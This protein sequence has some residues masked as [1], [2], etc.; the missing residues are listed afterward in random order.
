MTIK[1]TK[2][3]KIEQAGKKFKSYINTR[4]KWTFLGRFETEDSAMNTINR[5]IDK[6]NKSKIVQE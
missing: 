5:W 3:Y 2:E 1:Q 6:A 4:G